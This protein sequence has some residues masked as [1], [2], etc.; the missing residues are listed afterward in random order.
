[1]QLEGIAAPCCCVGTAARWALLTS[2]YMHPCGAACFCT[3][4]LGAVCVLRV[5]AWFCLLVRHLRMTG[6]GSGAALRGQMQLGFASECALSSI[7][8]YPLSVA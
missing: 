2:W 8:V 1:M 5:Q 6:V 3:Q 4:Q 7:V